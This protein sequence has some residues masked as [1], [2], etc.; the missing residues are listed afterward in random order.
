MEIYFHENSVINCD[1]K[2][3]EVGMKVR[4]EESEGEE[5]HQTSTVTVI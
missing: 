2:H 3:L 1:F 4:F 5:R